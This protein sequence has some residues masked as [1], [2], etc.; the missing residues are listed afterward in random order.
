MHKYIFNIIVFYYY[1]LYCWG[2]GFFCLFVLF[3]YFS[4][5]TN[6]QF[7]Q[8]VELPDFGFL[9]NAVYYPTD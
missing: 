6:V 4:I 7:L 9:D 8:H 2:F 5:S 1:I 3:F